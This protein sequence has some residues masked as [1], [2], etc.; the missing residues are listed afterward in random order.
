MARNS[1]KTT[2]STTAVMAKQQHLAESTNNQR[3]PV[4]L[5]Y[6]RTGNQSKPVQ[7]ADHPDEPKLKPEFKPEFKSEFKPESTEHKP[8]LKLTTRFKPTWSSKHGPDNS[9]L[10]FKP[11]SSIQFESTEPIKSIE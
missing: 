3:T 1:P 6:I 11:E 8:Q 7:P 10:K 2:T 4:H 5:K 9:K